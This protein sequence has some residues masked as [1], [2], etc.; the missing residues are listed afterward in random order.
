MDDIFGYNKKARGWRPEQVQSVRVTLRPTA[1][2]EQFKAMRVG[3]NGDQLE[4][5]QGAGPTEP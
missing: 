5:P 1:A 3:G 4:V 2:V